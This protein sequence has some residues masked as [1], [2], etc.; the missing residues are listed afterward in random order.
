MV[1]GFDDNI[2]TCPHCKAP[3]IR[4]AVYRDQYVSFKGPGFT[5]SVSPPKSPDLPSTKGES[6]DIAKEMLDDFAGN[7]MTYDDKHRDRKSYETDWSKDK[8]KDT[9]VDLRGLG[10]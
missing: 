8:P 7:Q 2:V 1:A 9:H 5:K 6:A 10:K 3:A 4:Q